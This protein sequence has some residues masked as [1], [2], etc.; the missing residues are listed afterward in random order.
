MER[1]VKSNL[2]DPSPN[3]SSWA[4]EQVARCP[5]FKMLGVTT[6]WFEADNTKLWYILHSMF[7]GSLSYPHMKAFASDKDGRAAYLA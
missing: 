3:Y 6:S 4:K 2:A 1:A 5:H 7:K